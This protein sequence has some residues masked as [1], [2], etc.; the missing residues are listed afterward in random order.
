M[1]ILENTSAIQTITS[2]DAD[3]D[4]SVSYSISSGSNQLAF[5]IDEYTGELAFI[6]APNYEL[7]TSYSV[8]V[9][10]SDGFSN[11]S[12]RLTVTVV[13][14]D[15]APVTRNDTLETDEDTVK[16]IDITT[17]LLANDTDPE[18]GQLT[19]VSLSPPLHGEI[20]ET[21]D[22]KLEYRP[23]ADFNGIDEFNYTVVD[24][25]GQQSTAKVTIKI[26]SVND[27][28]TLAPTPTESLTPRPGIIDQIVLDIG[29]LSLDENATSVAR[30]DAIDVDGQPVKY[31]LG[32]ADADLF[33]INTA[34]GELSLKAPLDFENPVDENG[35][36]QYE[37]E[38]FLSD[39]TGGLSRYR[40]T[41]VA[42]NI[43]EAP[44]IEESVFTV[45]EGYVG[46]VGQLDASDPDREDQLF[47]ELIGAES[48]DSDNSLSLGAD[49]SLSLI[50]ALVGT[51]VFE[52][53]VIDQDGLAAD[54][55]I[56]IKV[57]E[58]VSISGEPFVSEAM[59]MIS[60]G[61]SELTELNVGVNIVDQKY[62][63]ESQ[64]SYSISEN[65]SAT[66]G[67][68]SSESSV[69]QDISD[70]LRSIELI[71]IDNENL[72]GAINWNNKADLDL[73]EHQKNTNHNASDEYIDLQ[74]K[75]VLVPP[76]ISSFPAQISIELLD[77][78][79]VLTRDM[80][81]SQSK[82][83]AERQFKLII[84]TAAGAT[85][86]VGAALWLLQSRLLLA[87]ALAAMPLWRSF[88]PIPV[89]IY[90]G[91]QDREEES[92]NSNGGKNSAHGADSETRSDGHSKRV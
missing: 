90:K 45:S 74:R 67:F 83:M 13:D 4:S 52:V 72:L 8:E 62:P 56:T 35:D 41:I 85:F 19:L 88:D 82:A 17:D 18:G 21:G 91:A 38:F 26:R 60:V 7:K 15:E 2:F 42:S 64:S 44:T 61:G 1:Q 12:Q 10:V 77:A 69:T 33:D 14:T 81:E 86:S 47:F 53:R 87:A 9:S 32:G 46:S 39:D 71:Q 66:N 58:A 51:H 65:T 23:S 3:A 24:T 29:S 54:G 36:N 68:N 79:E 55:S 73:T 37:L 80:D 31:S 16:F 84:T 70:A 22:G 40:F 25:S 20:V 48:N 92:A 63:E 5:T 89:L 59:P 6:S 30:V 34:T 27:A 78:I 75:V 49:G 43:N 11:S 76:L 28:P 50:N 57:E